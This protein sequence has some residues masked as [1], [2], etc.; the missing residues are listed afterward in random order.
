MAEGVEMRPELLRGRYLLGHPVDVV[1]TD[2]AAGVGVVGGGDERL[3]EVAPREDRDRLVEHAPEVVQPSLADLRERLEALCGVDV[4]E[5]PELVLRAERR[6]PPGRR[7]RR[8]GCG[9]SDDHGV[10]KLGNSVR[11]PSTKMVWPVMYA[12]MSLARKH[13]TPA[14]SSASPARC[15]GMCSS[16]CARLT[17]SSIHARLIGVT[18]APGPMPLTRMPRPAYSSASVRVR[19]CMPPLLAEYPR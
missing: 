17:G 12:A 5:H 2:A 18:V 14:I 9:H 11:P 13:V 8:R 15:I 1:V 3:A 16:T 4:V 6:R 19:F 10:W 7:R